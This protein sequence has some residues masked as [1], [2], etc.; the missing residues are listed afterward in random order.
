V[1][2]R[3]HGEGGRRR[4][5]RRGLAEAGG[6]ARLARTQLP[7]R[8]AP[9]TPR[10]APCCTLPTAPRPASNCVG[11]LFT[12]ETP[13]HHDFVK[14]LLPGQFD[15]RLGVRRRGPATGAGGLAEAAMGADGMQE[16]RPAVSS[17]A[18]AAGIPLAACPRAGSRC[19][20]PRQV[21]VWMSEGAMA[22]MVLAAGPPKAL[23]QLAKSNDDLKDFTKRIDVARD[24]A[25][26]WPAG[27]PDGGRELAVHAES[28]GLFYD[29]LGDPRALAALT[30]EPEVL[31]HLRWA[32]GGG[33]LEGAEW[34]RRGAETGPVGGR[35]R[36]PPAPCGRPAWRRHA[37]L[38][39]AAQAWAPCPLPQPP[40]IPPPPK[41]HVLFDGGRRHPQ[42]EA[43]VHLR[44]AGAGADGRA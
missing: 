14:R 15:S 35:P 38:A 13:P 18:A 34:G 41:V 26:G 44:P 29:I 22:P 21:E 7:P 30:R 39:P 36:A 17:R 33:R 37:A 23:R 4:R 16:H 25:P 12:V 27:G 6:R 42:A 2:A 31:K 19:A 10:P 11:V 24:R 1:R 43:A 8:A 32:R 28:A 5:R 40:P 20:P 9:L 3:A